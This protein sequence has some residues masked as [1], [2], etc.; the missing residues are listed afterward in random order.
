ML[1]QCRGGQGSVLGV[2]ASLE[3]SL[4]MRYLLGEI[5]G[6]RVLRQ[7]RGGQGSVLGVQT[8]LVLTMWYFLGEIFGGTVLRQCHGGRGLVPG[9]QASLVWL[10]AVQQY[11]QALVGG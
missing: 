1:R 2:Q 6:E 9:V 10:P 8:S 7:C 4:T 3:Q 5:S 11:F